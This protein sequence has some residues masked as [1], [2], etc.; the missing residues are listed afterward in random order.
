VRLDNKQT[1][2]FQDLKLQVRVD[3]KTH[4]AVLADVD[5]GRRES[6]LV[7]KEKVDGTTVEFK[8]TGN[9]AVR[10]QEGRLLATGG[11]EGKFVAFIPDPK[12][13]AS[14][15]TG[16]KIKAFKTDYTVD[17]VDSVKGGQK[18][19]ISGQIG[20]KDNTLLTFADDAAMRL[21][22]GVQLKWGDMVIQQAQ[23]RESFIVEKGSLNM[24]PGAQALSLRDGSQM[25]FVRVQDPE[26]KTSRSYAAAILAGG[27][28]TDETGRDIAFIYNKDKGTSRL[29]QLNWFFNRVSVGEIPKNAKA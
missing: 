26:T 13:G 15:D 2:T 10:V 11:L 6:A 7:V 14:Q 18:L 21:A 23:A 3:P 8:A 4:Q 5:Y 17:R 25:A 9:V 1:L 22:P 27:R 20:L 29:C 28:I 12:A 19:Y 16:A 24:P